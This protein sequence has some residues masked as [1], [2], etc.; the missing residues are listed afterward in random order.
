MAYSAQRQIDALH[1]P[2]LPQHHGLHRKAPSV[3]ASDAPR[4]NTHTKRV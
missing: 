4:Y 1:P 2:W 3:F